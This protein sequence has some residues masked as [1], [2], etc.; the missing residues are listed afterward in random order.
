ME[1]V[2]ERIEDFPDYLVSN[3]GEVMHGETRKLIYQSATREG[4]IK[5]NLLEN[6]GIQRSRSVKVL[7]AEAFVKDQSDINNT[8][9]Q[10]DGNRRNVRADNLVWRP[11]WFAWKYS[12][13][14]V[15]VPEVHQKGPIRDVRTREIYETVY[16]TAIINGLLFK[17]IWRSLHK[18]ELYVY[19]TWQVFEFVR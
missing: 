2:W 6:G 14:F 12:R 5:V 8:A 15:N 13:Q 3:H 18:L 11:R 17:D 16:E 10:L 7:V 9:I 4:T 19:P 1:R